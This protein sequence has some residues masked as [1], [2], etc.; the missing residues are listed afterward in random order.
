MSKYC[1]VKHAA[2][3]YWPNYYTADPKEGVLKEASCHATYTGRNL[4]IASEYDSRSEAQLDCD[5]MNDENPSGGYAVCPIIE[6][7]AAQ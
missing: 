4:D 5:L 2:E 7:S 3:S 1:I 6:E